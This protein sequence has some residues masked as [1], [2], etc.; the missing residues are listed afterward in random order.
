MAAGV[1]P[2]IDPILV[3]KVSSE[4]TTERVTDLLLITKLRL[5]YFRTHGMPYPYCLSLLLKYPDLL[6][7][8]DYN[9]KNE[10]DL[11]EYIVK[12]K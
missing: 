4:I 1:I 3:R 6:T 10:K 12:D 8:K 2:K 11:K 7:W 9:I 5:F